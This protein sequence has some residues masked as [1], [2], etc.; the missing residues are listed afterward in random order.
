MGGQ[1]VDIQTALINSPLKV[2]KT[3]KKIEYFNH[4]CS[5]DIETT[6][7]Y[8]FNK[9]NS[10]YEK[11]AIMYEWTLCINGLVVIGR[12]WDEFLETYQIL[13]KY[14]NT[15]E[16]RRLVIY[17]HNLSFEFQFLRLWLNWI[18]V[19]SLDKRKPIQAV[20]ID[21][22]EFRCSY[23]LSG[24]S[25][26]KLGDQLVKY[27]V[28]K[29]VGD[30]D[31]SLI[32]HHKTLLTDKEIGYCV[33]DVMVVNNYIKELIE[34]YGNITKLPLTKTGFVRDYCRKS[35]YFEEVRSKSS[36]KYHKYRNL[37]KALTLDAKTYKMLKRAFMG[38]FTHANPFYSGDILHNVGS[39]DFGSSYPYVMISEK[40]PMSQPF[41][42][43]ITSIEQFKFNLLNY[44]CLFDV[45]FQGLRP[46]V[47]YENYLSESHCRKKVNIEVNNGRIVSADSLETTITEQD[48]FIIDQMYEWDNIVIKDFVRFVK[49]YL[50]TDF[51]KS[52]L[53]LYNDKTTLKEVEGKEIE[54]M[55]S[56]E[57]INSCF[58]MCVTDICRDEIIYDDIWDSETPDIEESIRKYN[59]SVK[60]FLYYPWGIWVTAY[61]RRNLFTGINEFKEDYVYSDTDSVKGLNVDKHMD[62]INKYNDMVKKKL[63]KAMKFHK[64]DISLTEP[65]NIKGK[66][67]RLGIWD[68]EGNYKT[69]KTLG[70]KRYMVEKDNGEISMTVSGVNKKQAVPYLLRKYGRDRI[71]EVFDNELKIPAKYIYE[72]EEL[73]ATGKM[74]HTYIDEEVR[75]SLIDYRGVKANYRELSGVHLE[76]ADYSLKLSDAYIDYI[77]GI[78]DL[79][80][81]YGKEWRSSTG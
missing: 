7:F 78:K 39:F 61:A 79:E 32:R 2:I 50:P 45:E 53:K 22:V 59:K 43:K 55:R 76:N 4:P 68:Y 27:P 62:Y 63:E 80:G 5:F 26:A 64:L 24:Y 29:L 52:I 10:T 28:K 51:V 20:T 33:N 65:K 11:R 31:Y 47:I 42:V 41:P 15:S 37:M 19:F 69:F 70:A 57:N 72:G 56:K 25:L 77:L 17:V 6:S 46:K 49:G 38:G 66:T 14:Y 71:F 81:Y 67:K 54:Y 35:C 12:T 13:V 34:Q 30:L 74:T 58:G 9:L 1:I 3:N 23:L 75:G 73:S 36:S 60:R 44:C 18:R 16:N 8:E 48:F 40:F 21:G